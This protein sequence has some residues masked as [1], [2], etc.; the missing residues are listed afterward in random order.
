MAKYSKLF[1]KKKLIKDRIY[2]HS[3]VNI[4]NILNKGK[5]EVPDLDPV[6]I[7]IIFIVIETLSYLL[8]SQLFPTFLQE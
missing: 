4:S 8:A 1:T 6:M 5:H 3:M 7:L 2:S